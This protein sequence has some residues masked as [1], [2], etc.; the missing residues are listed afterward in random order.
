MKI[1]PKLS[2]I[3][4]FTLLTTS[5][6]CADEVLP[7]QTLKANY[8]I[9]HNE[10]PKSV[11]SLTDMFQEGVFY[12]RLRSNTFLYDWERETASQNSHIVSG[13]GGSLVYKSAT[14]N[15]FDF[16]VGLYYSKAFLI[17]KMI[18]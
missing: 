3:A 1:N 8:Q 5:T 17:M 4:M 10:L 13:I 18:R 2:T 11:N 16:S 9:K 14:F 12:G 6:M 7:K 15:N